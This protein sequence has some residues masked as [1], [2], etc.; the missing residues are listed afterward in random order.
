[1]N[2][3]LTIWL[4]GPRRQALRERLI[5]RLQHHGAWVESF[6][7][8]RSTYRYFESEETQSQRLWEAAATLARRG[9]VVVVSAAGPAPHG[10]FSL[11]PGEEAVERIV[12]RLGA[13]GALNGP[14]GLS[15]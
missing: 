1:M 5:Q 14:L 3:G 15:A 6:D 2:A 9:A 4:N 13:P 10:T 8:D 12:D 7:G 11:P